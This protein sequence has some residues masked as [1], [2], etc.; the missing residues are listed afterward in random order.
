[1]KILFI[2]NPGSWGTMAS[3]A[4]L[5]RVYGADV[6]VQPRRHRYDPVVWTE[7]I[8][9]DEEFDLA[10]LDPGGLARPIEWGEIIVGFL[11]EHSVPTIIIATEG[12]Y[13]DNLDHLPWYAETGPES[14]FSEVAAEWFD[15]QGQE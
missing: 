7:E 8:L 2:A 5:R 6:R 14:Y 4:W 3:V 11:S 10:V 1:M 12:I 9:K 15:T 13:L